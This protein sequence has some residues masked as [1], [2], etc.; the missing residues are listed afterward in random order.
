LEALSDEDA[1]QKRI[2]IR[3]V[4]ASISEA[5]LTIAKAGGIR[6]A[7]PGDPET[8]IT[9][10][11]AD[12]PIERVLDFLAK[13]SN[14]EWTLTEEGVVVFRKA[15]KALETSPI[16]VEDS[17]TLEQKMAALL[18]SLNPTQMYKISMGLSLAYVEL[19]SYQKK[20]LS[21]ILS[22]PV[23][24]VTDSGEVVRDLPRPRDAQISF[25][26]LPYLLIPGKLGEESISL[27]LDSRPYIK[28]RKEESK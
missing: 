3:L 6:I 1:L 9:M 20:L 23:V 7:G 18:S 15:E 10:S 14:T 26:T 5:I 22:P 21:S 2:T 13:V 11:L 27:R 8:G 28:L 25:C 12:Q 24:G 4:D 19:S 16:Q 17:L